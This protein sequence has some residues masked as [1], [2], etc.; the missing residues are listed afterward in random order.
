LKRKIVDLPGNADFPM[1][2]VYAADREIGVAGAPIQG[3]GAGVY[4]AIF[5]E[6]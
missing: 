1:G 2:T 3:V 6:N 4:G 5:G